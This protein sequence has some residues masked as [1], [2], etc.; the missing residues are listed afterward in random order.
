MTALVFMSVLGWI[1]RFGILLGLLLL[2]YANYVILKDTS[3]DAGLRVLPC[4]HGA[5]VVYTLGICIG[6]L[7]GI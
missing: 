1:A 5:M 7:A 3:P 6:V 4:F 2:A